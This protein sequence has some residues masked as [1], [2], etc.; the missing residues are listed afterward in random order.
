MGLTETSSLVL[1]IGA[2]I[3]AHTLLLASLVGPNGRVM[4]FEPDDFAFR[5][6]RRNLDLN[7]QVT[8]RVET[9]RCFLT[10]SAN[11]QGCAGTKMLDRAIACAIVPF[12]R[13][14]SLK[15]PS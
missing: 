4:A 9:L 3:G 15:S 5:K 2:S 6:L 8:S 10:A 14:A 7:P 1:D 11:Q 12:Q 13:C